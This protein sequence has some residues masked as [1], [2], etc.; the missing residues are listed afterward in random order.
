MYIGIMSG[1]SI[2]A[3][4]AVLVSF[5]DSGTHTQPTL[6]QQHTH[7]FSSAL[8]QAL[9]RLCHSGDNE[10]E[11]M[12]QASHQ[13]AIEYA[14]AVQALLEHA[15][16]N[17]DQVTAIG[18]HGQTIRHRPNQ[19]HPFTLQ[20][21]DHFTLAVKTGINVIGDF[22]SKDMA[23]GGQGAP[24]V[25]AFHKAVFQNDKHDVVVVNLGGIANITYLPTN[26]AKA[27]PIIG[28]DTGPANTLLDGWIRHVKHKHYDMSGAWASQ[29]TV[30]QDLLTALLADPYFAQAYPKSTGREYF[31]L[32]W[33]AS[34]L[35][36]GQQLNDFKPEDIQATLAEL[37][38]ITV[39]DAIKQISD[40]AHV[41]ICGGGAY[42]QKLMYGLSHHLPNYPFAATDMLGIAPN[43][44]E[45][46]AFA[47]LAYAYEKRISGNI[48]S[49]TGA[50]KDTVLGV[51]YSFN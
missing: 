9:N 35:P 13:L 33:L 18:C 34:L 10:I 29:G 30:N 36:N 5:D 6:I 7:P 47:W 40:S 37:T 44:V 2:D 23:L 32:D 8:Q 28:F 45:A 48:A 15:D 4:D 21:G 20:I 50:S 26:T 1:T 46:M 39:A 43:W 31:N 14:D 42:N 12:G 51:K 17:A 19:D 22:R 16:I 41:Y 3:I 25:P 24:L 27:P 11:L 49:V 38:C